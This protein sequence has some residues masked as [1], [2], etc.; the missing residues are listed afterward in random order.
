MGFFGWAPEDRRD[1]AGQA[2]Q[3]RSTASSPRNTWNAGSSRRP[4]DGFP[5]ASSRERPRTE[6]P[7]LTPRTR[8]S[9]ERG[10][11]S[12]GA[13]RR[14]GAQR[15]GSERPRGGGRPAATLVTLAPVRGHADTTA[16][17]D[18]IVPA[19]VPAMTST[20]HGGAPCHNDR[21]AG[22]SLQVPVLAPLDARLREQIAG[23]SMM[24]GVFSSSGDVRRNG[25]R[26]PGMEP[27]LGRRG[28]LELMMAQA[29][30]MC[31]TIG[32]LLD[33]EDGRS[34]MRPMLPEVNRKQHLRGEDDK[35]ATR[36]PPPL[37]ALDDPVLEKGL[38]A[39]DAWQSTRHST[40]KNGS[41]SQRL[42][43][44]AG[45]Q[46]PSSRASDSG[47][48]GP[49][50]DRQPSLSDRQPSV[51]LTPVAR[52][53]AARER[54][55]L[56]RWHLIREG[57]DGKRIGSSDCVE[58][59]APQESTVETIVAEP[60][61]RGLSAA[62]FRHFFS[63]HCG[64]IVGDDEAD[65]GASA[66]C[67][68]MALA[69]LCVCHNLKL[70]PNERPFETNLY[71]VNTFFIKPLTSPP[72]HQSS[73]SYAELV[74]PEG[75]LCDF[76]M[77]H[78]WGEDFGELVQGVLRHAAWS[79]P[80]FGT[81]PEEL[82]YWCCA[83]ANNQHFIQ[84][85]DKLEDSPFYMAL[86]S[87]R[88]KGTIMNLNRVASALQRTW[89]IYETH[90]THVL[91]KSFTIN[92]PQGPLVDVGPS[93][94]EKDLWVRHIFRLL[95][96]INVAHASATNAADHK[97]IMGE[98]GQFM[99]P[100]GQ[101]GAL[102]LNSSVRAMMA[103]EALSA[104][105]RSGDAALVREALELRADLCCKDRHGVRPLTHAAGGGHSDVEAVLIEMRA[106]PRGREGAASVLAMW[107]TEAHLRQ[108]AIEDV[109]RLCNSA[110]LMEVHGEALEQARLGNAAVRAGE[111]QGALASSNVLLRL[112]AIGEMGE[113][114][115]TLAEK[116]ALGAA[117]RHVLK[118]SR[119]L[120]DADPTV[121]MATVNAF[122][123]LRCL[124]LCDVVMHR[125]DVP[126]ENLDKVLVQD[127]GETVMLL[128][129]NSASELGLYALATGIRL[130]FPR[131]VFDAS[132]YRRRGVA[133]LAAAKGHASSLQILV[134]ECGLNAQV[135][136]KPDAD[137][138]TVLHHACSSGSLETLRTVWKLGGFVVR[139]LFLRDRGQKSVAHIAA[140][141]RGGAPIL[142]A[143]VK[144]LGMAPEF[145]AAQDASGQTVAHLAAKA[146]DV[147]TIR[148]LLD[149]CHVDLKSFQ[150]R[151]MWART[152]AHL[153]A[154]SDAGEAL[155]LLAERR[156]PCHLSLGSA[157]VD[158]GSV[159]L[160]RHQDFSGVDVWR[161]GKVTYI[162][163]FGHMKFSYE[164]A[165][166]SA[167][168]QETIE[169]ERC[170][171]AP[172]PLVLAQAL[173][174]N[175]AAFVLQ[176]C[177]K[178]VTD[179]VRMSNEDLHREMS[180]GSL[181]VG[182]LAASAKHEV[183]LSNVVS[184]RICGLD[185]ADRDGLGR[186]ALHRA[187]AS[188]C[189]KTASTVLDV[190]CFAVEDLT[191]A[192]DFGW[193]AVHHAAKSGHAECVQVLLDRCEFKRE[194]HVADT[195]HRT[196]VHVAACADAAAV[197]GLKDFAAVLHLP[198]GPAKLEPDSVALVRVAQGVRGCAQDASALGVE[199]RLGVV[200]KVSSDNSLSFKYEGGGREAVVDPERCI[201]APTAFVLADCLGCNNAAN[202]FRD[203][204]RQWADRLDLPADTLVQEAARGA[205]PLGIIASRGLAGLLQDL[206]A[207]GEFRACDFRRPDA[208]GRT[209]LHRAARSGSAEALRAVADL[210]QIT[211][212]DLRARDLKG[213]N[214][215]HHVARSGDGRCAKLVCQL[216][217]QHNI[218]EHD[219]DDSDAVL[220]AEDGWLRTPAHVAAAAD[221]GEVLEVLW[222]AHALLDHEMGPRKLEDG[223]VAFAPLDTGELAFLR[224]HVNGGTVTAVSEKGDR[225]TNIDLRGGVFGPTP[226]ELA[227]KLGCTSAIEVLNR[228]AAFKAGLVR[229]V[230]SQKMSILA[231]MARLA[232]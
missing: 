133:H 217:E 25:A 6:L 168:D 63:A 50:L 2:A 189:A 31:Q 195:W 73:I 49:S 18:A 109:A 166:G 198:M 212:G 124:H 138:R 165:K 164:D 110:A 169:V 107:S 131:S 42:S 228:Y 142:R 155:E 210:G 8:A 229:K 94:H 76:F 60:A 72:Q 98:I 74:N 44:G 55:G 39:L 90:L 61:A 145:L 137:G 27:S 23:L 14:N 71:A 4:A 220:D 88:C 227:T 16:R 33:H 192:D 105:A 100:D 36:R 19:P 3:G 96:H 87:E 93:S 126:C 222:E 80:F 51:G 197:L 214:L 30:R 219:G 40:S 204:W 143:L 28:W 193:N 182:I 121:Q 148:V 47:P 231:T 58:I 159:A 167:R 215:L 24:C 54:E 144:E 230:S 106:D 64:E 111:L 187:A 226:L 213:R 128:V 179:N 186:T 79:A 81:K 207:A 120:A 62:Q 38:K 151:D 59:A 1:H 57:I 134:E 118:L 130:P 20:W 125:G 53:P 10:A 117:L 13:R 34:R 181:P 196:A 163:R 152:P 203:H 11:S 158:K 66:V 176:Q 99:T 174:C 43:A 52:P 35:D 221:H 26:G 101:V 205:D 194:D 32:E 84:L 83:F 91:E 89:C 150:A 146:G 5:P 201:V 173:G 208:Q 82:A 218:D 122:S 202:F 209:P 85:G 139:D 132:D 172:T 113:H 37:L 29:P 22:A 119:C 46:C 190:G 68:P 191:E 225:F 41:I 12:S 160:V 97:K 175:H 170:K 216:L 161:L 149:D 21:T 140:E 154:V 102:A 56:R 92:T 112:E 178:V 69:E 86:Q 177:W 70:E 157:Q 180:M 78:H 200:T 232:A 223:A 147:Q 185:F 104:L 211:V 9:V 114:L 156:V 184:G 129:A 7:E 77:S 95:R 162:D 127:T 224:C 15:G 115:V 67:L 135:F 153:A 17:L 103:N 108:R 183:L 136:K 116:G 206:Y 45:S 123:G 141:N 188:G 199:W 171:F 65:S 48:P 75:L